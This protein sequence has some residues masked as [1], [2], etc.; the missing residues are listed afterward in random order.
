MTKLERQRKRLHILVTKL[1][2]MTE[3]ETA[4]MHHLIREIHG[5]EESNELQGRDHR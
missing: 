5:S 1:G 2:E 3:A 4:W